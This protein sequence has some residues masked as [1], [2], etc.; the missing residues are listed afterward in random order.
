MAILLTL[1]VAAPASA[2]GF[3]KC[4][5]LEGFQSRVPGNYTVVIFTDGSGWICVP[6]KTR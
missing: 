2:T 6:K 3:D 1:I 5:N 4:P